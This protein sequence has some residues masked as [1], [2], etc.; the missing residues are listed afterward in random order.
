MS[1]QSQATQGLLSGMEILAVSDN[2]TVCSM[3]AWRT[4]SQ[5]KGI[6]VDDTIVGGKIVFQQ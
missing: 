5:M 1:H 4:R 3:A 2:A 6:K